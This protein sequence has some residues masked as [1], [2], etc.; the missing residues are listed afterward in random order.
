MPGQLRSRA[1]EIPGGSGASLSELRSG[2][3]LPC[4][5]GT[6][7]LPSQ[8]D[9]DASRQVLEAEGFHDI[10]IASKA[11]DVLLGRVSHCEE[12]DGDGVSFGAKALDEAGSVFVR[13]TYVDDNER[14]PKVR[15]CV[16]R[17]SSGRGWCNRKPLVP[18]RH[19]D[20]VADVAFVIN[21]QNP[22]R[23]PHLI[24]VKPEA[25]S[26]VRVRTEWLFG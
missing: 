16:V 23:A 22:C 18:E 10:V 4:L 14:G 11:A 2:Y 13:E 25:Q 17:L 26:S 8:H 6:T 21:D 12:D 24:S 19:R 5:G 20:K 3:H 1:R 9:A 7:R 15:N